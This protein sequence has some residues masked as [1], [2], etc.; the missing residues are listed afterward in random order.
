M[1]IRSTQQNILILALK[2]RGERIKTIKGI[3]AK[4]I[5]NTYV[6]FIKC[7]KGY[8]T[9]CSI[10]VCFLVIEMCDLLFLV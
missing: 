2:N 6:L 1:K 7:I 8:K 3:K 9:G 10:L 5:V 4:E